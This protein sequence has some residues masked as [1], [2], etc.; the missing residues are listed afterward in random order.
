MSR[1]R[2]GHSPPWVGGLQRC[3]VLASKSVRVV[4]LVRLLVA[5]F[6]S[7][8]KRICLFSFVSS[9]ELNPVD[10]AFFKRSWGLRVSSSIFLTGDNFW[11]K[12]RNYSYLV[13]SPIFQELF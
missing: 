6:F 1:C 5:H 13:N 10:G 9:F 8:Q 3:V 7:L 11:S 12:I 2:R 4:V